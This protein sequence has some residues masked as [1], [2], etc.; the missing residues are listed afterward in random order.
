MTDRSWQLR[1]E[2]ILE[3]MERIHAYTSGM[4]LDDFRAETR[5]GDAVERNFVVIGEAARHIPDD[6]LAEHPEI[7]WHLLRGMRDMLVGYFDVSPDA[8][9]RTIEEDL[10]PLVPSLQRMLESARE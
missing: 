9:W 4:S 10:P 6:V 8:V 7:P 1:V 5:T 3:C 2:D